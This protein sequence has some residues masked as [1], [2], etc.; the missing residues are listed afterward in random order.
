VRLAVALRGFWLLAGGVRINMLAFVSCHPPDP[1]A[2]R[3]GCR[4]LKGARR[5]GRP[6]AGRRAWSSTIRPPPPHDGAWPRGGV[7][8]GRSGGASFAA[9]GGLVLYGASNGADDHRGG[10]TAGCSAAAL[11]HAHRRTVPSRIDRC[12]GPVAASFMWS[13]TG[14]PARSGLV[15]ACWPRR[16]RAGGAH[17]RFERGTYDRHRRTQAG[18]G[19]AAQPRLLLHRCR[20][21]RAARVAAAGPRPART[22]PP[23]GGDPPAPVFSLARLR[24]ARA[25]G[26]HAGDH[27]RGRIGGGVARVPG[28]G[29]GVR[30][31]HRSLR[32]GPARRLLRVRLSCGGGGRAVGS[33]ATPAARSR[34]ELGAPG[35]LR[36]GRRAGDRPVDGLARGADHAI[37]RGMAAR[38]AAPRQR[39]AIVD[40]H[41]ALFPGSSCS[42]GC[43]RRVAWRRWWPTRRG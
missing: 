27:R 38:A 18:I 29:P 23:A 43:S 16:L 7:A 9:R 37:P 12:R 6:D 26:A 34:A 21:E 13:A 30:S 2:G 36:G 22:H 41:P 35:A 24:V 8:A 40:E 20:R 3:W 31:A 4:P 42:S 14:R 39:I 17:P 25:R 19:R 15:L 11:R 5:S 1:D 10:Q 32:S 28:S 33:T